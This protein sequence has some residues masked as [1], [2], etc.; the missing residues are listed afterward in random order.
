P[1]LFVAVGLDAKPVIHNRNHFSP[2]KA[3]RG[4]AATKR[5]KRFNR[6]E[7]SAAKPQPKKIRNG[8]LTAKNAKDAKKESGFVGAGL[9]PALL[10]LAHREI[11]ARRPNFDV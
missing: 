3:Q 11:C 2:R 4:E 1:L 10:D 6:K 7:L 8:I 9:K 5:N